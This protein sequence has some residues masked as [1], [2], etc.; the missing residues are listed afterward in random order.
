MTGRG[1]GRSSGSTG[2]NLSREGRVGRRRSQSRTASRAQSAFDLG[3][4]AGAR[5]SDG[6]AYDCRLGAACTRNLDGKRSHRSAMK[7]VGKVGD[8]PWCS[9]RWTQHQR[10]VP[11]DGPSPG[12]ASNISAQAPRGHGR[13]QRAA[14]IAISI[15][16]RA[17]SVLDQ[18]GKEGACG[19][20]GWGRRERR[21][22]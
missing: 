16:P 6:W 10:G 14:R 15:S 22:V 13:Q 11:V 12:R 1:I 18:G 8:R 9:D 17:V 19:E 4:A 21:G 7:H 5:S 2:A 3:S 20:C